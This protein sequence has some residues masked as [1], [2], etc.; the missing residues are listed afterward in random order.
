MLALVLLATACIV[1]ALVTARRNHQSKVLALIHH[2]SPTNNKQELDDCM[3]NELLILPRGI[4]LPA[5]P[6]RILSTLHDHNEGEVLRQ[7]R[8]TRQMLHRHRM[9]LSLHAHKAVSLM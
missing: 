8:H 2:Y 1:P 6:I 3:P 4:A 7:P 9:A 5:D